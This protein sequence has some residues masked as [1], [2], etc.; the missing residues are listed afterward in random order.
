MTQFSLYI[1]RVIRKLLFEFF[2]GSRAYLN[3]RFLMHPTVD[4]VPIYNG[5]FVH[6]PSNGIFPLFVCCWSH[7]TASIT[8][9]TYAYSDFT[10]TSDVE[11]RNAGNRAWKATQ[12][13]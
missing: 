13:S 6:M 1:D 2:L 7:P 12:P 9:K 11:L 5:I 3:C 10:Y 8:I 4:R